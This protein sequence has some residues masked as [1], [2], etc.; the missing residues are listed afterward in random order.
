MISLKK[1]KKSDPQRIHIFEIQ[2]L[3]K[4]HE[5]RQNPGRGY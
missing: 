5:M 4:N 2:E 1:G 3:T